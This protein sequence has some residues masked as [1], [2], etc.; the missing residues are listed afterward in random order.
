MVPKLGAFA[1]RLVPATGET[2]AHYPNGQIKLYAEAN[3]HLDRLLAPDTTIP[4]YRSIAGMLAERIHP[5]KLP[6]LEVTSKPVA[7]ED[8]PGHELWGLYQVKGRSGAMSV[9]V[10]AGLF[11]LLWSITTSPPA[12]KVAE[13]ITLLV[14]PPAAI[15]EA[16][17][18]KPPSSG[19]GGG[20][21]RSALTS[22]VAVAAEPPRPIVRHYTPPAVERPQFEVPPVLFTPPEW[23]GSTDPSARYG[24]PL[25]GLVG[26]AGN[27]GTGMGYGNGNGTGAG[28]GSGGG[29]G[30]GRGGGYG[31]GTGPGN[32][33]GEPVYVNAK[34]MTPP[35]PVFRADAEYT[36]EARKAELSGKVVLS[37]IVETNGTA[38]DI[39]VTKALGMGL[40]QKAIEAVR[41]WKFKPATIAG[42]PVRARVN[43]EVAFRL[44]VS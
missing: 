28:A 30:G 26:A 16:V 2:A 6:P 43:V 19:G 44:V 8:M 27:F 15:H 29:Y 7:P 5:E 41:Q 42:K 10:H 37:L 34:G 40:E 3:D 4:W 12:A 1:T 21:G 35:E 36:D 18:V 9:L 13:R 33:G 11:C 17:K 23:V 20:G 38:S 25:A 22:P 39:E 31:S 14:A 24:D 32:G